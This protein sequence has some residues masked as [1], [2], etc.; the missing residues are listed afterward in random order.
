MRGILGI[1]ARAGDFA[2]L[3][4][5]AV[6]LFKR[7]E[8]LVAEGKIDP[9]ARVRHSP[10]AGV[11]PCSD[12]ELR[13]GIFP[14][15]A[16]PLH[17]AH[18][19]GGLVAMEQLR[20]DKV[21]YVIAGMD[22]RKP[23]LAPQGARHAMSR[24][25][26]RLFHP[27]FEY[28]SIAFGT[29]RTG[30]ENLFNILELNPA[31]PLHAFY[32]AG[33]DHFHRFNPSTGNPDT[34]QKLEEGMASWLSGAHGRLHRVSAVF[35]RRGGEEAHVP[36]SLDVHCVG[37]L[38]LQTSSTEIRRALANHGNLS[39]LSALPFIELGSI[40]GSGL[41]R[42]RA[43]SDAGRLEWKEESTCGKD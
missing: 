34:I 38:P 8:P 14:T 20:L 6:A 32:I 25:V 42:V 12:R 33:G 15:A 36:T 28:S 35:L 39:K 19:L 24:E 16:N 22:P 10:G 23:D 21:I 27:L 13:I 37:S 11:I 1:H 26:L 40:R 2:D 18:L 9:L 43:C 31:Q 4:Q 7:I 3:E 5:G 17:W 30:E 41:Y 29:E